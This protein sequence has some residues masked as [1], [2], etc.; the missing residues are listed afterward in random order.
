MSMV[1]RINAYQC[2]LSTPIPCPSLPRSAKLESPKENIVDE[3]VDLEDVLLCFLDG[4][5]FS[6]REQMSELARK[7]SFGFETVVSSS[8]SP[9]RIDV[10]LSALTRVRIVMLDSL[11]IVLEIKKQDRCKSAELS[12]GIFVVAGSINHAA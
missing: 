6:A 7:L 10:S 2:I 8:L 11:S 1:L 4:N 5:F 12:I 3:R 9:F